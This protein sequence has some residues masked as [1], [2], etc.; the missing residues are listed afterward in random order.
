[1]DELH[2]GSKFILTVRDEDKWYDSM[3]RHFGAHSCAMRSVLYGAEAPGPVGNETIYKERLR[4]HDREVKEYFKGRP[5][6][7]LVLDV[8]KGSSWEAICPFLHEPVPAQ[9]FPHANSSA[10]RERRN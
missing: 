9:P 1:M 2:P 10:Q 5:D 7:L 8:T 3:V 6:D 4:R